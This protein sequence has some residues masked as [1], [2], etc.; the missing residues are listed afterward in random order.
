MRRLPP[1][2]PAPG[3][4]FFNGPPGGQKR[5]HRQDA[6]NAKEIGSSLGALGGFAVRKSGET[7]C[8]RRRPTKPIRI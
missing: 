5:I 2:R 8:H 7:F 6:K 1:I 4:I 3:R